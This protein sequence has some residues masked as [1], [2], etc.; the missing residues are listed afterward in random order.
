MVDNNVP[1]FALQVTTN[2]SE[3]QSVFPN[4]AEA[5]DARAEAGRRVEQVLNEPSRHLK[6]GRHVPHSRPVQDQPQHQGKVEPL[7]TEICF[8]VGLLGFLIFFKT[9]FLLLLIPVVN[10]I[11][12]TIL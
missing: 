8:F 10:L 12:C 3:V 4:L 7:D 2:L 1:S 5:L 11:T 6:L 9:K